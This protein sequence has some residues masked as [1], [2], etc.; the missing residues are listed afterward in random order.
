MFTARKAD[1][2][3]NNMYTS[4]VYLGTFS[5]LYT[6]FVSWYLFY[7]LC[8]YLGMVSWLYTLC[9]YFGILV[10]FP[11]CTLCWCLGTLSW[12]WTWL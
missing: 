12:L 5:W 3:T 8:W 11:G 7:T 1:Q 4:L 6:L 10:T 2:D 9:W